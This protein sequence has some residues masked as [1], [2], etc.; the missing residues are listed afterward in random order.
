MLIKNSFFVIVLHSSLRRFGSFSE[1]FPG[2]TR[3]DNEERED[4]NIWLN[5]AIRELCSVLITGR[6]VYIHWKRK[7]LVLYTLR[8]V[9]AKFYF[10]KC[11]RIID[12]WLSP[13]LWI[14]RCGISAIYFPRNSVTIVSLEFPS[15]NDPGS[16][17]IFSSLV[18]GSKAFTCLFFFTIA[19]SHGDLS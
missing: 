8:M 19:M 18:R 3:C 13:F 10:F 16:E 11:K 12:L 5:S 4:A 1:V 14:V 15:R 2:L 7:K 6:R 9:R 17:E